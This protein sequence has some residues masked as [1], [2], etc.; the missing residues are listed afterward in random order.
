MQEPTDRE[1]VWWG[2]TYWGEG[3]RVPLEP[4]DWWAVDE[5]VLPCLRIEASLAHLK[6]DDAWW[7][8]DHLLIENIT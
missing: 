6:F 4:R 7:M 1:G 3:K 5:D 8:L 2:V